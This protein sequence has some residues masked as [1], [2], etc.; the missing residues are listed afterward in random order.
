MNQITDYKS[1]ITI[2]QNYILK[3]NIK[4]FHSKYFTKKLGIVFS[5]YK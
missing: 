5:Q 4:G 1:I 2:K 3:T